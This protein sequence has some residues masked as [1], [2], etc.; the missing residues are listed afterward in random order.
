MTTLSSG[1][2]F[3]PRNVLN[4]MFV[5]ETSYNTSSECTVYRSRVVCLQT[6]IK[7]K[8]QKRKNAKLLVLNKRFYFILL[9]LSKNVF[10]SFVKDR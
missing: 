3:T 2:L 5:W 1:Y 8:S 4:F 9:V 10:K 7:A 6:A